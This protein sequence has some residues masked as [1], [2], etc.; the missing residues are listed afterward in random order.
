MRTHLTSL[1][2]L[3][4]ASESEREALGVLFESGDMSIELW[5]DD[6]D[7]VMIESSIPVPIFRL[8]NHTVNASEVT[9][10]ATLE[11]RNGWLIFDANL[12]H[13]T[14][15]IGHGLTHVVVCMARKTLSAV[16]VP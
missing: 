1:E 12:A 9:I 3:E 8:V 6:D 7:A 5:F 10:I 13:G 14:V 11:Q 16:T 2:I 15:Y 4:E